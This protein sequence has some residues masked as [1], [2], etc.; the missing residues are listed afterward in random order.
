MR[1]RPALAALTVTVLAA[2]AAV[3]APAVAAPDYVKHPT[4]VGTG[5]AV[6]SA[7]LDASAAGIQVLKAGGNA[8]D[9]AVAV[10]ST[11]GVTE[12]FVA[13]PGGG[14]YMV[15]YLA[16]SHKVDHP[17]RAR[18]VPAGLH[19]AA[20]PRRGRHPDCRSRTPA[21]RACPSACRAWSRP[22]PRR[23]SRYGRRTFAQN[24]QPAI[25]VASRRLPDRRAVRRSRSRPR[26]PTCSR[27]PAAARCSCAPN[28]EP[29]KVG[30]LFRNPDLAQTYRDLAAKGPGYLYGGPLGDRT[31]VHGAAPAGGAGPERVPD[32][33]GHH[34]PL[35][36]REL[37]ASSSRHRRT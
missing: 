25:D 29:L 2:G 19:A 24:L 3:G 34:D 37:H 1:I 20:V 5:G 4:A 8:I 11:L 26:S 21:A 23:P 9:A 6:A 12:P 14:G 36:R 30:T 33:A 32:H 10:A 35:G 27:S 13:G 31:R 18:A 16:H 15:I 22:G 7:D 17:G 28:G